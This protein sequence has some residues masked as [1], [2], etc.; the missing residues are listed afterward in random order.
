M[1]GFAAH[2]RGDEKAEEKEYRKVLDMLRAE[3][4]KH[5]RGLTGSLDD[6]KELETCIRTILSGN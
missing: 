5:Q 1:T 3:R 2:S 4:G 6:D